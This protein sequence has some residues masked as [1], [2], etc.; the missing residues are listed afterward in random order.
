MRGERCRTARLV[1]CR[2]GKMYRTD[3]WGLTGGV[4]ASEGSGGTTIGRH[5][6]RT[7]S[8]MVLGLTSG[9]CT[10]IAYH[11]ASSYFDL[12]MTLSRGVNVVQRSVV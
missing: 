6:L 11:C 3:R 2:L 10:T 9:E 1:G 12:V 8:N 7:Y 4:V 5:H